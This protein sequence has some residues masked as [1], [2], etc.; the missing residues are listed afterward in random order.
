MDEDL[1]ARIH[2]AVVADGLTGQPHWR[3]A[4]ERCDGLT[5]EFTHLLSR[6]RRLRDVVGEQVL[7]RVRDNRDV[8]LAVIA[9]VSVA[10]RWGAS[11]STSAVGA[12]A[13]TS[14]SELKAALTRLADEHLVA[15]DS[16]AVRGLH[17]LRSA[18]LCAAV[19][20]VPPP[21]LAGTVRS[22]AAH[23][24][25][26]ELA[27]FTAR[28]IADRPAL[29]VPVADALEDRMT[30]A[31]A[32]LGTTA[33]ALAGLRLADFTATA[34]R[35]VAVLEQH[36]VPVP[37]RPLAIDLGMI[38][39]EL[40]DA[41]DPRL[42]AAVE[43][44]RLVRAA[45]GSPLRD[46]LSDAVGESSVSALVHA[47]ADVHD[48]ASLLA[49]LAGTGLALGSAPPDAPLREAARTAPLAALAEL[50]ATGSHVSDPTAR[51][52][53]DTAGGQDAVVGRLLQDHPWLL[54]ADVV[55]D[56][57]G[58]VLRGRVLHV[59]D[60]HDHDPERSIKDLAALGLRLLPHVD[61]ADLTTVM[62]G[63]VP[64]G[65]NGRDFAVSGLLRQYA[66]GASSVAWNRERSRYAR[67]LV[68][69]MSTTE[70]LHAGLAVLEGTEVFL[71]DFAGAWVTNRAVGQ[72][73]DSLNRKRAALLDQIQ[74]LVPEVAP[75]PVLAGTAEPDNALGRDPVHGA[76]QAIV[77]DLPAR[78]S[79]PAQYRPLA[80]FVA[81][82][83]PKE[84]RAA[85]HGP[86]ALL[87]L[88]RPPR[89]LAALTLLSEQL[90]AV[91][92]ERA[93][94]DT[95]P[96][97]VAKA[98]RAMP[99]GKALARAAAMC[100]ARARWR[101]AEALDALRARAAARGFR[102]DAVSRPEPDP[103]GATWPPVRTRRHRSRRCR[104]A[105]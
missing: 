31:P 18:A 73:L 55:D 64:Y 26:D 27:A 63:G 65:Y 68:G 24:D 1:A 25:P 44:I 17:P 80:A 36:A 83:I 84:L 102:I 5:L 42:V 95:P 69:A 78:I 90:A 15:V 20:D 38:D 100:T 11:L 89:A 13:G 79:D 61:R 28:A 40:L 101:H 86:W 43:Q 75:Q 62:A 76:A 91:L 52:L 81:S 37:L 71:A 67:S 8:E 56:G 77:R 46:R 19:R 45:S 16:G 10:H 21:V 93:F 60:R 58:T 32:H 82:T 23:V 9:P 49:P 74:A 3:E 103:H 47:A 53:L 70:R 96:A 6:G 12:L 48:A 51:E 72:R 34:R 57:D 99:R 97:Q 41:F 7:A 54:G 50:I 22:V 2:A 14:D 105:R 4:Y 94:G 98:T 33:A 104:R 92:S 66:E 30:G 88:D 39:S 87:G 35:W 59:S 29:A 85:E